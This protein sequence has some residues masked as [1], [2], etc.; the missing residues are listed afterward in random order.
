RKRLAL[1]KRADK[2]ARVV[3][4]GLEGPPFHVQNKIGIGV[5]AA[6]PSVTR[7]EDKQSVLNRR[8][9]AILGRPTIERV[10]VEQR[11]TEPRRGSLLR[12][13]PHVTG[14]Q[15]GNGD[16]NRKARHSTRD[17]RLHPTAT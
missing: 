17:R 9:A 11:V 16:K 2:D 10:A 15:R 13:C 4:C 1:R 12:R 8:F 6:E 7:L 5:I 14:N 3:I